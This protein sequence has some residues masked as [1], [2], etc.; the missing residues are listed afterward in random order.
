MAPVG[1]WLVLVG[2]NTGCLPTASPGE[3]RPSDSD[4][5]RGPG[6]TYVAG[7]GWVAYN[8]YGPE[9]EIYFVIAGSA[10]HLVLEADGASHGQ[11]CPAFSLDGA[12][13][14][15][16]EGGYGQ[17]LPQD[18]ALVISE[19]TADGEVSTS[20]V[21]PLDGLR[22]Q[23]CP[24]W[25]PDGRWVAFGVGSGASSHTWAYPAALEVWAFSAETREVR[26][27]RG[28]SATDIEWSAD[29]SQLY[30]AARNG[31]EVYSI[32]DDETRTL[33]DSWGA[34]AL[35]ASPDGGSLA[36]E[37]RIDGRVGLT[38]HFELL[39]M[40][41]DGTD[42]R[43]LVEDY[44]HNRGIGPVW[45]PDGRR[46][47]FQGGGGA[48]LVFSYGETFTDGEKDEAIIVTVGDDDPLGP[49]GTQTV[50]APIE[51]KEGGGTRHWLPATVSWSPDSAAL[52]FVGWELSEAG[53]PASSALLTVPV[54]GTAASILWEGPAAGPATSIPQNDFQSWSR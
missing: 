32:A 33:D 37:R 51:T 18:G 39:L 2:A 30:M 19:L 42:R 38:D 23:P 3:D 31:I 43:V 8:T 45:S 27:L 21:I 26:R 10:P 40:D 34:V 14:A 54:D 53:G 50:L 5:T 11:V 29:S 13:L 52:R 36:V 41:A 24:I 25:S 17:Q 49:A 48:P 4:P 12:R 46:I 9:E 28:L 35:S 44:A 22:Q 6:P 1:V 16:G 15:S 47:V 7:G 20:E